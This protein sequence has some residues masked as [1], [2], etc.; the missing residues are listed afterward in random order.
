MQPFKNIERAFDVVFDM[1]N[2]CRWIK[3]FAATCSRAIV[4]KPESFSQRQRIEIGF[5][6]GAFVGVRVP[7][8]QS[9]LLGPCLSRFALQ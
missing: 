7:P 6:I 5:L 3:S 9:L 4:Q 2:A 1:R 8:F